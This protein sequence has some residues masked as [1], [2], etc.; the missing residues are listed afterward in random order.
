MRVLL[1][2]RLIDIL[3]RE[4]EESKRLSLI[5]RWV[6][7]DEITEGELKKLIPYVL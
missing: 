6:R 5:L 7:E 4:K 2:Q 3:H 1:T